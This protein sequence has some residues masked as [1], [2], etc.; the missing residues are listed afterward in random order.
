MGI[1]GRRYRGT[2]IPGPGQVLQGGQTEWRRVC[3][4]TG[5]ERLEGNQGRITA[6][7]SPGHL[8]KCVLS[9]GSGKSF[10]FSGKR[11]PIL[12]LCLGAITLAT[13]WAVGGDQELGGR[14]GSDFIGQRERHS[15]Q[16]KAK[17]RAVVGLLGSFLGFRKSHS[18]WTSLRKGVPLGCGASPAGMQMSLIPLSQTFGQCSEAHA[19]ALTMVSE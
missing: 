13:A 12:N 11:V 1:L 7:L 4:K 17:E 2:E 6:G 9:E 16:T 10:K 3:G 18:L 19:M 14:L 15:G 8:N 5:R